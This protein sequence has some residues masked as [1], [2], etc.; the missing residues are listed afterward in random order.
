MTAFAGT[1]WQL[2]LTTRLERWQILLW[3]A[4]IAA[5]LAAITDSMASLYPTAADR[6]QY[7]AINDASPALR[8][9]NG[10]GHALDT[11]GG[12]V[13][14]EVGGYLLVAVALMA[15]LGVTRLTRSEEEHGRAEL[16]L[17]TATGTLASLAAAVLTMVATS[18]LIG[19]TCAAVMMLLGLP[20]DGAWAYGASVAAIGVFFVGVT[21]LAAQVCGTAGETL[22]LSGLVIAASYGIR[23]AGDVGDGELSAWSPFGWVQYAAPF[24]DTQRSWPLGI[25]AGAGLLLVTGAMA[26]RL[27][28]DLGSALLTRG[29]GRPTAGPSLVGLLTATARVAAPAVA[30]WAL[31]G[32]FVGA[33]FG[34]AGDEVTKVFAATPEIGLLL[35]TGQAE[36]TEGYLRLVVLLIALLATGYAVS[37]LQRVRTTERNGLGDLTLAA[38]VSRT[39]WL[40]SG[41]LPSLLGS[42]VVLAAGTTALGGTFAGVTDDPGWME[43]VLSSGM[44]HLPAVWLVASIA[45]ALL[46]ALPRFFVAAWA[47][48][49]A[50]VVIDMLGP[51]LQL[52]DGV[53]DVS[54]FAHV[55][56]LPDVDPGTGVWV[57]GVASLVLLI[58][59]DLGMRRRDLG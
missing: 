20:A 18:A 14:F 17:S 42:A 10:P 24:A 5:L 57:M 39:R 53:S 48:L 28:R 40:L 44:W 7:A 49:A 43:R 52:A 33:V 31:G 23:A 8:A 30:G 21:A 16:A 38:S 50:C 54:P 4:G 56:Q 29:P 9:I 41:V 19:A 51:A 35:G 34:F 11:P 58:V 37:A 26:V 15:V 12:I 13:V 22:G 2:R 25:A 36:A 27:R 47:L 6:E 3:T 55:P 45:V 1:G 32:L 46:G 59:G